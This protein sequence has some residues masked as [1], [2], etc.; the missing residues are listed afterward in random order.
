MLRIFD[1]C[2]RSKSA[3]L[4]VSYEG[5][6]DAFREE[7]CGLQLNARFESEKQG[8]FTAEAKIGLF[9]EAKLLQLEFSTGTLLLQDDL[10]IRKAGKV[11]ILA[12]EGDCRWQHNETRLG[13][14]AGVIVIPP[15]ARDFHLSVSANESTPGKLYCIQSSDRIFGPNANIKQMR[16]I[17]SSHVLKSISAHIHNV[18]EL[19][20]SK[21]KSIFRIIFQRK[22]AQPNETDGI[23]L[24]YLEAILNF[25]DS[26][27]K[28]ELLDC[29]LIGRHFGISKRK[30]YEIF[31][32]NG[33]LLHETIVSRRLAMIKNEIDAGSEKVSSIIS[34]YGFST[35]STFYRNYRKY[36]GVRPRREVGLR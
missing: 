30:I 11:L 14:C 2:S 5:R 32:Q 27:L 24:I 23:D 17:N 31:K 4:T 3:H 7:L 35:P 20:A 6:A 18:K 26:N 21:L 33:I 13:T 34:D 22:Y 10:P 8:P 12:V 9:E 16:F 29:D 36:Y 28:N 25:I 15:D 19:N 1:T